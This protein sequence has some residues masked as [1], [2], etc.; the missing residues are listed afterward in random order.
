MNL[1][2]QTI[3]CLTILTL[4]TGIIYPLVITG[5]A[6][7]FFPHQANGSLIFKDSKAVG[8]SLIGQ[9]FESPKYFWSRPSVTSPMPYNAANSSG[10]NLGTL[11]PALMQNVNA[12]IAKLK[13]FDAD[14]KTKIPVDL[15]TASGSGLDPDISPAA[16]DYQ[17]SRVA[18]A[19]G[20][21]ETQIKNL[22]VKHTR[23]EQLG[24]FGQRRVNVVELNLALDAL[25][26]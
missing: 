14:N 23:K 26:K 6:Q 4:L 10:S 16:A 1:L 17:V 25:E 3:L 15:V 8:S 22:I 21:N 13:S 20:L 24:F 18:K 9:S 19:R 5:I 7:L 12:R 11:N 2:K